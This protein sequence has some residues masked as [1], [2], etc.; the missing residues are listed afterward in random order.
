[1]KRSEVTETTTITVRV[2]T[3][4]RERLDRLASVTRRSR[5]FLAADALERYLQQE[6][7][8]IDAI[9]EG[10]DDMRAGRVVPHEQVVAETDAI[11]AAARARQ[12]A[13][14]SKPKKSSGR[15]K[16]TAA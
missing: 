4:A 14:K 6:L 15:R 9:D 8:I 7:E 2:T 11:I 5:S 16:A 13:A 1:V 12:T 3:D 10:I